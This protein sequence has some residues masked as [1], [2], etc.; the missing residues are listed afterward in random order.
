MTEQS[1]TA[2][3]RLVIRELELRCVIGVEEWE[4]RMPQRVVADIEVKGDFSAAAGSDDL[5][6]AMDYRVVCA[7][8][9]EVAEEGEYRLLETLADRIA[10]TVL[11]IDEC[12]AEVR[13]GVFKPL[14]L[15]GF[16][17]ARVV[18]EVGRERKVPDNAERPI[19]TE[20]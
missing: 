7:T 1:E 5:V 10:R 16:G 17:D 4:R 9:V 20:N 6:C 12:V 15:A 18:M 19:Q 3:D 2:S 11:G 8:A 13:V 14:A